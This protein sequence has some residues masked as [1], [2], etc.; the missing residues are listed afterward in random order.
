MFVAGESALHLAIVYGNLAAVKLLVQNGAIVNQ[1]AAG[2]FFLP[3]DMK[4][5]HKKKTLQDTNYEG[6]GHKYKHCRI[7]N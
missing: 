4:K 5:G 2:R 3:E 6:K 7:G 1:R